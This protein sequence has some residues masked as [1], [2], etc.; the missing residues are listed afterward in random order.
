MVLDYRYFSKHTLD[1][2]QRTQNIAEG[3]G[4]REIRLEHLFLAM[5]HAEDTDAYFVL[6]DCDIIASKLM[7]FVK[8]KQ[9][10]APENLEANIQISDDVKAVLEHAV[11]ATQTRKSTFVTSA[12]LLI[13]L[14]NYES[15]V[16]TDILAH[17]DISRATVIYQ[18]A[19][20]LALD[21]SVEGSSA[22]DTAFIAADE[23]NTKRF[24]TSILNFLGIH[25][26][27][28]KRHE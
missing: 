12:H 8:R 5:T 14:M 28:R 21:K 20:Y 22:Q 2:L 25:R 16:I 4:Q 18:A 13:G 6:A 26:S 27:K 11:I 10:P 9:A 17:F 1:V 3:L 24:V 19:Q 15:D 7:P 23:G